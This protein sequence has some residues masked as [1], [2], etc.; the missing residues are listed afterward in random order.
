M[1]GRE[2][3]INPP[4]RHFMSAKST[5]YQLRPSALDTR[6]DLIVVGWREAVALPELGLDSV[7]AKLDTGATM[8]TLH[9]I[10]LDVYTRS[11]QK[12]VRFYSAESG[13]SL[14]DCHARLI[15][16]RNIKSSNGH[17]ESRPVIETLIYI[18]GFQ[19]PIEVTLTNRESLECRMLIGRNALAGRCL[20][21]CSRVGLVS[22][23]EPRA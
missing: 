17:V 5:R 6:D 19:W 15:C 18:A 12:W 4:V 22:R 9:A 23:L 20:V 14:E 8:S 3:F 1:I 13:Q 2:Q 21:D 7:L 10:N 11:C 16:F